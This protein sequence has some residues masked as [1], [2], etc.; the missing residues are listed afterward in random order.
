M[1]R[2]QV[3]LLYRLGRDELHGRAL[4]RLSVTEVVLLALE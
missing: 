2:L 1:R 3:D 4:D